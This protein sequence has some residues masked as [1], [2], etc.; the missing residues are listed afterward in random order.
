MSSIWTLKIKNALTLLATVNAPSLATPVAHFRFVHRLH[1]GQF[2]HR[3][4]NSKEAVGVWQSRPKHL[5][6]SRLSTENKNNE[7]FPSANPEVIQKPLTFTF[8]QNK[9]S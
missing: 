7:H 5:T 6:G 3:F 1:T 9:I 4:R 2:G 8:R